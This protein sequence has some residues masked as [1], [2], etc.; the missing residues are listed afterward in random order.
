MNA[1]DDKPNVSTPSPEYQAMKPKWDIV[2]DVMGGNEAIKDAGDTYLPRM[3]GEKSDSDSYEARLQRSLFTNYY[4]D[5]LTLLMGKVFKKPVSFGDSM[6]QPYIDYS[7]DIDLHGRNLQRYLQKVFFQGIR[8]RIVYLF[9][10]YP[11]TDKIKE[12]IGKRPDQPLTKEDMKKHKVRPYLVHKDP[13]DVIE[14]KTEWKRGRKVCVRARIRE[15]VE[16]QDPENEWGVI[17]IEQIRVL[18]P[19]YWEV[20]RLSEDTNEWYVYESGTVSLQ[21][22]VPGIMIV[23]DP[24][25]EDHFVGLL[26]LE[27]VLWLNLYHYQTD[28]DQKNILHYA[29]RYT[30]FGKGIP[31]DETVEWGPNRV[32]TT[33]NEN[34]DM[35]ILEHGGQAIEAG[36]KDRQDAVDEIRRAGMEM[37]VEREG[38]VKATTDLLDAQGKNSKLGVMV[39]VFA[40]GV[41]VAFQYMAEWNQDDPEKVIGDVILNTDFEISMSEFQKLEI[42]DKG[43]G[44]T[45]ISQRTYLERLVKF[46]IL[47]KDH[48][49]E[50]EIEAIKLEKQQNGFS[51]LEFEADEEYPEE[52]DESEEMEEVA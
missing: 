27:N 51:T 22:H 37:L 40:D 2:D 36:R 52:L 30:L 44:R 29:R 20:H 32:Y 7:E 14:F 6:A 49:I 46:E 28:S 41:T 5:T 26:P 23:L 31:E 24:D 33:Q 45:D 47:D 1:T 35:K 19:G 13:R 10:A 16:E 8:D 11:N 34:A 38:D 42:L 12:E 21:S 4:K 15:T 17:E 18:Y 50:A 3:E 9:A 25:G 43:R 48:D 39:N